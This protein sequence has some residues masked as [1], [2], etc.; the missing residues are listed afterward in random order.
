MIVKGE[1]T[2]NINGTEYWT[3]RQ[4]CYLTER[5][6]PSIVQLINEGN[7]IRKLKV[8]KVEKKT[9]IEAKELFD[10][11]FVGMGRPSVMGI[12]I[13]K[14]KLDGNNDLIKEDRVYQDVN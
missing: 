13:E 1:E 12:P 8:L 4:F 14:F 7:K 10:F 9:F 2:V 3:I 5:G 6:E 11:P